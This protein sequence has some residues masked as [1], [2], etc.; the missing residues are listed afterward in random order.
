MI[1]DALWHQR[2]P[3]LLVA[4]MEDA[5]ARQFDESVEPGFLCGPAEHL[6]KHLARSALE[7]EFAEKN[8][9]S[10]LGARFGFCG[11]VALAHPLREL[12]LE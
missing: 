9:A 8:L 7:A 4:G 6:W 1:A 10:Y 12:Q 11:Y 5:L 3:A 2:K